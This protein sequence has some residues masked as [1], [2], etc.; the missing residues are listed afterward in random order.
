MYN[1]FTNSNH[2]AEQLFTNF[3]AFIKNKGDKS[4]N[5]Y[6]TSCGIV[7]TSPL[8]YF[9]E[10]C[11][12]HKTEIASDIDFTDKQDKYILDL[13]LTSL[14]NL[15][16]VFSHGSPESMEVHCD[17]SKQ[18]AN[19]KGFWKAF[20]NN[21]N[22]IYDTYF[23]SGAQLTFN[24]TQEPILEDS[25]KIIQLQISDLLASSVYQA[26]L[27]PETDFSKTIK[28]ISQTAYV[29]AYSI[30][31][32]ELE[33]TFDEFEIK[34]FNKIIKLLASE[35]SKDKKAK[36]RLC[37]NARPVFCMLYNRKEKKKHR[38]CDASFALAAPRGIEPLISP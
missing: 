14:Y 11:N 3:Y 4:L 15:L 19:E 34:Q 20:I 23:N 36:N 8:F 24:I 2:S 21:T 18:I 12:Q 16:G 17:N 26:Y 27:H 6:V 30:A 13:T 38:F 5:E 37:E 29:E 33:F 7:K 32:V 9:C 22:I 28:K 35:N 1:L 10:F 31:P 25:K